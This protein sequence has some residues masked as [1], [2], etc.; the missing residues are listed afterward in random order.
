M[1]LVFWTCLGVITLAYAGYPLYMWFRARCWPRP[2]RR[3][4]GWLPNVSV[5]LAVRNGEKQLA[6]KLRNL[7][8]MDYPRNLLQ[9]VAISDG[10]TDGTNEILK[11]WAGPGR[12]AVLLRDHHGKSNALNHG[13][14]RARGEIVGFVDVAQT[15]APDALRILVEQFAD[16]TVGCISGEL[17][18]PAK[19]GAGHGVGVY[20]RLE[21]QIRQWESRTGSMVGATGAFYAVRRNALA[22]IPDGTILDDMYIPL[23]VARDGLRVVFE[24]GAQI[25]ETRT[26]GARD[27]FRRRVRTL[28]GN[29][30]LLKIA[31]WVVTRPSDVRFRFIC[32]KLLR[33]LVPFALMGLFLATCSIRQ[34]PYELALLFQVLFYAFGA[35]AISRTRFG[36]LSRVASVSLA[37]LILNTAAAVAFFYYVSGKRPA[38]AD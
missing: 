3:K 15:M 32:H 16:P 23:R 29:Y 18:T 30:Q 38:W 35:V 22:R 11:R 9:I 10:S 12:E 24:P 21:T 13:I 36:F 7:E 19:R 2:A 34:G 1:K 14:D 6:H 37:F 8:E 33:L 20:W 28:T 25:I 27:E 17:V 5:I 26:F 31:P 4:K